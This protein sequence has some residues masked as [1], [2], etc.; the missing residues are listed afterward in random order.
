MGP[1][2]R[3]PRRWR[4]AL[5]WPTRDASIAHGPGLLTVPLGA[6]SIRVGGRPDRP[7]YLSLGGPDFSR[8]GAPWRH[9]EQM[10]GAHRLAGP[11][12]EVLAVTRKRTRWLTQ[13]ELS[14]V[15]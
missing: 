13:T 4:G 8:L 2:G 11:E 5:G 12:V 15:S 9:V 3:Q 7:R 6:W 10:G 1:A 14:V